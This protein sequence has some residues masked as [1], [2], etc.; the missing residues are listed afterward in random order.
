M[1]RFYNNERVNKIKETFPVH[2]ELV[3][4]EVDALPEIKN[5]VHVI[6]GIV[7]AIENCGNFVKTQKKK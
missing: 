6:E 3:A 1:S 5:Y 4:I 2:I 7:Q